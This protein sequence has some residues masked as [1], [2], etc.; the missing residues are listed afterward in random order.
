MLILNVIG[1]LDVMK[2]LTQNNIKVTFLV[3]LIIKLFV[4]MIDLLSESL[5]IEMKMHL[6]NL[7]KQFLRSISTAER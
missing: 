7:L 1:V 6:V 5:F 3:V 4:L 2:V